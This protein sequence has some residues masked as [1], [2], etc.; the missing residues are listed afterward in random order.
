MQ[1]LRPFV[2]VCVLVV[3]SLVRSQAEQIVISEIMYHP[4]AGKHEFVE[5]R[6][7]TATPFDIAK[8]RL[9]DGAD[10]DFPDFS[11]GNP[12]NTF[13]KAFE[14]IVICSTDPATFRSAYGLAPSIRVFGPWSGSLSNGGER[15][16]LKDKNGVVRCTGKVQ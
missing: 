1:K 10:F 12:Q 4:P 7:L 6:N 14:R 13:L 11:A 5:I 16:T 15:V 9:R 3:C 2:A 8:W